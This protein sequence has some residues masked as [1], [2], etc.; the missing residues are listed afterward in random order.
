LSSIGLTTIKPQILVC[1]PSNAAV[2]EIA[3][4]AISAG[5]IDAEGN[6]R[7]D[8]EMLRIGQGKSED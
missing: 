1:A 2:D 5:F 7:N 6:K 8:I 3:L 4:R